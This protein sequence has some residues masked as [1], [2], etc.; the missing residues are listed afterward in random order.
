MTN[1]PLPVEQ[2]DRLADAWRGME[3]APKDGTKID[4]WIKPDG[5]STTGE[6]WP[7]YRVADAYWQGTEKRG[8]WWTQNRDYDGNDGVM[9]RDEIPTHWRPLPEAPADV[10]EEI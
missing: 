1:K 2:R 6:Q 9:G 3:S 10:K 8:W 7:E 5:Q 4:L